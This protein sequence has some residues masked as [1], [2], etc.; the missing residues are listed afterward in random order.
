MASKAKELGPVVVTNPDIHLYSSKSDEANVPAG[1]TLLRVYLTRWATFGAGGFAEDE[2]QCRI[3]TEVVRSGRTV[4]KYGPFFG[5]VDY[6]VTEMTTAEGRYKVFR[7]AAR[8]AIDEMAR[9][10]PQG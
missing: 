3:F 7:D 6:S 8:A 9:T 4:G 2:V 5:R 1:A 10:L